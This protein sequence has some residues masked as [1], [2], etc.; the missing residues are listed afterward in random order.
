MCTYVGIS[1]GRDLRVYA[2]KSLGRMNLLVPYSHFLRSSVRVQCCS[3]QGTPKFPTKKVS[4][5]PPLTMSFCK[6]E[7]YV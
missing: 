6:L 5:L 1:G 4:E 7:K 2:R 3:S